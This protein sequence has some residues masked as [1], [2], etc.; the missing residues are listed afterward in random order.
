MSWQ[1]NVPVFV[2]V[3]EFSAGWEN[4]EF[5]LLSQKDTV[6]SSTHF[7]IAFQEQLESVEASKT[8]VA[9]N[10]IQKSSRNE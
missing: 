7:L 9:M 4:G 10:R 3:Q 5:A 8:Q 1:G 2:P 6:P